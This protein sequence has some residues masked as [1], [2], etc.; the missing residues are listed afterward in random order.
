[1]AIARV[2]N[3]N[4]EYH[5]EGEGPPL[6]MIIGAGGNAGSW[7]ES[8]LELLRP[9]FQTIRFSHG[10]TGA[11]DSP[12]GEVTMRTMADDAAG[13]LRQLGI[14]RAH[15]LGLSMGGYVALELALNYREIIIGLVLGGADCGVV[16][17]VPQTA[18]T[19]ARIG[20]L[21]ALPEE[22]RM[23]QFCL[24]LVTPRFGEEAKAF[25]EEITE[26]ILSTSMETLGRQ[27]MAIQSFDC[28]DRL[29]EIKA[30]TLIIHG[31]E[32]II[33]PPKNAAILQDRITGS[34][35]HIMPGVGHVFL[36]EEPK[37]SA[38]AIVKFLSSV[39]TPT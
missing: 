13:L 6:L 23:R 1:M 28:Y 20:Q 11:S 19:I 4:I 33:V 25:M 24:L 36:W 30:Q 32:D 9:H 3:T 2:G 7:G 35:A 15:V 31:E 22:Q 27:T 10:G 38:D 16:H 17:S 29:P 14:E 18:E 26:T 5:V 37:K 34:T 12:S 39:P 8:F 21:A